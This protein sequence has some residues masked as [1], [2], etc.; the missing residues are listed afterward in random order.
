MTAVVPSEE[1]TVL[2][3]LPSKGEMYPL[4]TAALTRA[5][6]SHRKLAIDYVGALILDQLG[7]L[8]RIERIEVLG[9]WGT[10]FGRKLLSRLTDAWSINVH[11]S[12]LREISLDQ[13]KD[14]IAACAHSPQSIDS[15]DFDGAG[16]SN[17]FVA[18]I[19]AAVNRNELVA[20]LKL[21]APDAALDVL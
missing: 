21:P 2:L 17:Q 16:G 13:L 5:Q 7:N 6:T 11:L 1:K 8:K 19:R 9:P 18:A 4:N 20:C 3:L 10:S 12:E 14:V 15:M